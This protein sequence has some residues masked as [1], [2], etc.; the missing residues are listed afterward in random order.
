[1]KILTR[2]L[3]PTGTH[4]PEGWETAPSKAEFGS[5]KRAAMS[6]HTTR[7]RQIE[8]TRAKT[9]NSVSLEIP[10]ASQRSKHSNRG[11]K[12][13]TSMNKKVSNWSSRL[14]L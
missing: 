3:A 9:A 8:R 5:R 13:V 1:M 11:A 10:G 6:K 12:N 14:I 2:R 4:A 7:T